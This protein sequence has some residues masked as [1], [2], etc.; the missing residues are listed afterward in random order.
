MVDAVYRNPS[1][2]S[3][4]SGL[5]PAQL[6]D[7]LALVNEYLVKR[8]APDPLPA[9]SQVQIYDLAGFKLSYA[10]GSEVMNLFHVSMTVLQDGAFAVAL[11]ANAAAYA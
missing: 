10:M 6:E 2:S 4:S 5:T 11:D 3:S 8:A 7:H 9:G 1:S